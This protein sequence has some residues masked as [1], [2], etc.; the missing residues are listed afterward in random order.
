MYLRRDCSTEW[1]SVGL[2]VACLIMSLTP[3]LSRDLHIYNIY[4]GYDLFFFQLLIRFRSWQDN[5]FHTQASAVSIWSHTALSFAHLSPVWVACFQEVCSSCCLLLEDGKE[6]AFSNFYLG[7]IAQS[8]ESIMR[9][10]PSNLESLPFTADDNQIISEI[11]NPRESCGSQTENREHISPKK[12]L[13][14]S[15]SEL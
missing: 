9:V 7:I 3:P 10:W 12:G 5:Y 14:W 11:W 8:C 4:S 15:H 13:S 6:A 2:Q 1:D